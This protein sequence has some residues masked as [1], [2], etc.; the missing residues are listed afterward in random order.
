MRLLRGDMVSEYADLYGEWQ[1][2]EV[3]LFRDILRADSNVIEVGAHIGM[4]S[5]PLSRIASQ[6]QVV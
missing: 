5:V 2:L 3:C 1:E 6:G 4:H